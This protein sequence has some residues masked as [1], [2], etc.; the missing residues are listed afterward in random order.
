MT[1]HSSDHRTISG[2]PTS[3]HPH[4][5]STHVDQMLAPDRLRQTEHPGQD[6]GCTKTTARFAAELSRLQR[7][8]ETE[9]QKRMNAAR[10]VIQRYDC[11]P[12]ERRRKAALWA[13]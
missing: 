4:L 5:I 2:S 1:L 3:H 10:V 12:N 7:Q 13:I 8:R 6:D 11:T 9:K